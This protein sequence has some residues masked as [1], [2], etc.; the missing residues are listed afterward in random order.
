MV[1]VWRVCHTNGGNSPGG[2]GAGCRSLLSRPKARSDTPQG[3]GAGV[4]QSSGRSRGVGETRYLQ[5]APPTDRWVSP[6]PA[7]PAEPV[8]VPRPVLLMCDYPDYVGSDDI[9]LSPLSDS[10]LI[11]MYHTPFQVRWRILRLPANPML[12]PTATT[13]AV[14]PGGHQYAPQRAVVDVDALALSKQFAQVGVVG[15]EVAGTG[16]VQH[17]SSG[18]LRCCVG[19]PTTAMAVTS[20]ATSSL[21][22]AARMRLVWRV[23]TPINSAAWS[24]IIY[25]AHRLFRTLS[26]ACCFWFNVTFS[27]RGV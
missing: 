13:R 27:I 26:L 24:A 1:W 8:P 19:R 6:D 23:L 12:W 3:C 22:Y 11:T 14:Q 20:A 16:K 7:S 21:R 10:R 5:T 17:R 2:T 9:L 4:P 25:S 15:S 18:C